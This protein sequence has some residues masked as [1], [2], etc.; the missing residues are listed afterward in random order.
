MNFLIVEFGDVLD[1]LLDARKGRITLHHGERVRLDDPH[2]DAAGEVDVGNVT[3]RA[4]ADDK[5]RP[6][7]PVFGLEAGREVIGLSEIGGIHIAIYDADETAIYLISHCIANSRGGNLGL[8]S[9]FRMPGLSGQ[10]MSG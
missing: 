4:F 2:I 3:K 5:E 8:L 6:R 9:F 1:I 10:G 7:S